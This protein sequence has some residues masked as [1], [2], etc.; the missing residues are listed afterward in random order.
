MTR[1]KEL[2]LSRPELWIDFGITTIL[3]PR[4]LNDSDLK[5]TL[6]DP[7]TGSPQTNYDG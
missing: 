2:L 7:R 5:K 1:K 6:V 4:L 3:V